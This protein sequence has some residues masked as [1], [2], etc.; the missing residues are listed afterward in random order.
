MKTTKLSVL[1]TFVEF[2]SGITKYYLE[3]YVGALV[4]FESTI[5][6]N[7]NLATSYFH[8]ASVKKLQGDL[9]GAMV[10]YSI[11]G[12]MGYMP[13]YDSIQKYTVEDNEEL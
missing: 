11:A 8:R 5:A 10:D 3:D 13:A 2:F 7:P 1:I 6:L 4:D 9:E 12:E